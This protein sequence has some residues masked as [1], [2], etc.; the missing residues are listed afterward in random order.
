MT[1]RPES[2]PLEFYL[3]GARDV[4]LRTGDFQCAPLR[5]NVLEKIRRE[6]DRCRGLRGCGGRRVDVLFFRNRFW[7]R[8]M[9]N[10]GFV[11]VFLAFDFR[12]LKRP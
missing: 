8:L 1:A 3:A 4:P 7:L 11:L 2:S 9:V 12:F 6:T 10:A 5:P